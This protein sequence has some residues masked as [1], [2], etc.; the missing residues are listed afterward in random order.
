MHDF[1]RHVGAIEMRE[2]TELEVKE[3]IVFQERYPGIFSEQLQ[4][5]TNDSLKGG[6]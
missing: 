1:N 6:E 3:I 5:D 4:K 2:Q